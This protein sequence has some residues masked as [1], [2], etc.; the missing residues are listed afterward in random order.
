MHRLFVCIAGVADQLQTNFASDLRNIL[1]CVFLMNSSP[2]SGDEEMKSDE[3]TD[4]PETTSSTITTNNN[5]NNSSENGQGPTV[6]LQIVE[7]ELDDTNH[8]SETSENLFLL[9]DFFV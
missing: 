7:E 8:S 4:P 1:K 9:K 6:A 2:L 5:N 3:V